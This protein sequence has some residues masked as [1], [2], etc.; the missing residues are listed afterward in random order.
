MGWKALGVRS[1]Q[2]AVPKETADGHEMD[3]EGLKTWMKA[4]GSVMS[5]EK[6]VLPYSDIWTQILG[7][8]RVKEFHS[9]FLIT[10]N[11]SISKCNGECPPLRCD[12]QRLAASAQSRLAGACWVMQPPFADHHNGRATH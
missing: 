6:S 3:M 1:E 11:Q 5:G 4:R 12:Q 10:T 7:D 2:L 8:W 9:L